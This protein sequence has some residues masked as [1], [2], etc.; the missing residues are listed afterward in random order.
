[1]PILIRLILFIVA[2]GSFAVPSAQ[3]QIFDPNYPVCIHIYGEQLGE[4]MDCIFKSLTQCAATAS[5]LPA[6]CL[7]N[8]YFKANRADNSTSGPRGKVTAN[9]RLA[10]RSHPE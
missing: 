2:L 10:H 9:H 6:I 3:A 8:P 1:M 4:R 7:V 5:G